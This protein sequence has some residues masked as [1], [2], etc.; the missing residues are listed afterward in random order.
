MCSRAWKVLLVAA[1]A[2]AFALAGCGSDDNGTNGGGDTGGDFDIDVSSGTKPTYTWDAGNAFS[3]SVTRK[4]NPA[5]I[6][7]GLSD[8]TNAGTISSPVELGVSGAA[9][10]TSTQ[11]Q[12][13]TA[14]VEYQISITLHDSRTGWAF[15]TP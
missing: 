3:L 13:L 10:P 11:E 6:V 5:N 4:S 9:I 14:G 7:W 12:T 2:S 8:P 15:F 1:M